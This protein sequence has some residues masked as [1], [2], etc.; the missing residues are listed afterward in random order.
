MFYNAIDFYFKL[1]ILYQSK[2]TQ[3]KEEK[4]NDNRALLMR[5]Q[6]A[7]KRKLLASANSAEIIEFKN[8]VEQ[9]QTEVCKFY[10]FENNPHKHWVSRVPYSGSLQRVY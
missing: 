4:E 3:V 6:E 8:K 2:L 5:C 1:L 7:E 10:H 9:L